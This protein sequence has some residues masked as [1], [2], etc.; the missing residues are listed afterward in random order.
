VA[1]G[2]GVVS[3]VVDGGYVVGVRVRVVVPPAD[4]TWVAPGPRLTSGMAMAAAPASREPT[5]A[6]AMAARAPLLAFS[7]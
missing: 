5:A 3:G 4:T 2:T 7:I 6:L 1:N